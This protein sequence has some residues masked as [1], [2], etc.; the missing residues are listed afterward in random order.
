MQFGFLERL[1]CLIR[2]QCQHAD[3]DSTLA[4]ALFELARKANATAP[5]DCAPA[6]PVQHV[7]LGDVYVNSPTLSD[8]TFLVE[9]R[10]FHAHRIALLASSDTFRAMF[11][12]HYKEKDASVIP[13]PNIRYDVFEAMMRCIYTG[14]LQR[15]LPLCGMLLP[16]LDM[17]AVPSV[18]AHHSYRFHDAFL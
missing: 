1:L 10:R 7:Y 6:P 18:H 2:G 16:R 17:L 5:I 12:G 8:V 3:H 14:A 4:G 11:D 9:G 13:I 15:H